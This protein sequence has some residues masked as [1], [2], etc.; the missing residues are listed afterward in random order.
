MKNM[1][2]KIILV[3]NDD[4]LYAPG[5]WELVRVAKKLGNVMVIAPD[6]EMSGAGHSLTLR[7]VIRIRQVDECSY[8]VEGSP[9]DCV[10]MALWHL[11]ERKPDLVLSGINNG[12]NIG[13]DALYSGTIAA[14]MEG[15]I[16]FIPA[17]AVS[18]QNGKNA[19]FRK[20]ADIAFS[21]AQLVLSNSLPKRTFISINVPSGRIKGIK[22]TSLGTRKHKN[23]VIE[24]TDPRGESYYWLARAEPE[25]QPD[26]I[27]DINVLKANYVSITPLKVDM[28]DY[29]A[30]KIMAQWNLEKIK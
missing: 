24:K 18:C 15:A 1:N 9:C 23:I 16:H 30:L 20:A 28:T 26:E 22:I 17:I 12:W 6:R 8:A 19:Q 2:K 14:A 3:T 11:L 29:E 25:Y 27:S 21:I 5:L 4:G 13:E 7:E 10:N